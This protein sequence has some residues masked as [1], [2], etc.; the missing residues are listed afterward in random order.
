MQ[1]ATIKNE[2]GDEWAIWMAISQ[3]SFQTGYNE[4]G[5]DFSEEK[6]LEHNSESGT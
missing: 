6:I 3:Y 2:D 1:S 5:P 4:G